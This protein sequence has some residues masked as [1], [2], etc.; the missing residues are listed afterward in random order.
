MSCIACE[1]EGYYCKIKD[2]GVCLCPEHMENDIEYD[3][4][5]LG[6]IPVQL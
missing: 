4:I 5:E 1:R 2:M 6:H 3:S